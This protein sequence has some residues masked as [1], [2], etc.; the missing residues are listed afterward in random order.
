MMNSETTS[1]TS[2]L[3]VG[4]L[5]ALAFLELFSPPSTLRKAWVCPPR[6]TCYCAPCGRYYGAPWRYPFTPMALALLADQRRNCGGRFS[7][8]AY[9]VRISR[10]EGRAS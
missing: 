6:S 2:H 10:Q 7:F 3:R 8:L 5:N 1:P 4:A 9:G